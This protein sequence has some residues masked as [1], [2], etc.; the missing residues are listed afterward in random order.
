METECLWASPQRRSCSMFKHSPDDGDAFGYLSLMVTVGR[1]YSLRLGF[2]H[3][4]AKYSQASRSVMMSFL[5]GVLMKIDS[6]PLGSEY[7]FPVFLLSTF[8]AKGEV[9]CF[10]NL[11]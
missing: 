4:F 5:V 6:G 10:F 7:F 3:R 11:S 2:F 9:F 8:V 1:V